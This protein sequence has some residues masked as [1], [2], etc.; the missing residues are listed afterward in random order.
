M[1]L[2]WLLIGLLLFIGVSQATIPPTYG[3]GYISPM[4]ND[5]TV[6]NVT[7]NTSVQFMTTDM[8]PLFAWQ[9][10][11][12]IAL[13]FFILSLIFSSI[14]MFNNVDGICAMC[15][16]ISF[17]ILALTSNYVAATE[18]FGVGN[19]PIKGGSGTYAVYSMQQVNVWQLDYITY[20]WWFMFIVSILNMIRIVVNHGRAALEEAQSGREQR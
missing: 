5:A 13:L 1:K 20:F 15:A 4:F 3:T 18:S 9:T 12:L 14:K 7:Y 2:K 8:Y 17:L 6:S 11:I 10:M 16:I 19:L